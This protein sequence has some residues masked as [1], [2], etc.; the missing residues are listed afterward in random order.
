MR[1]RRDLQLSS[2]NLNRHNRMEN[3]EFHSITY[4]RFMGSHFFDRIVLACQEHYPNLKKEAF[5]EPCKDEFVKIFPNHKKYLPDSIWY[6]SEERD[7]FNKPLY[8]NTK[9]KPEWRP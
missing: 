4:D 8:R 9:Q 7:E 6:F 5:T 3:F 1:R 2:T